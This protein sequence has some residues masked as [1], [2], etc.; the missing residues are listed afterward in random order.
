M[1]VCAITGRRLRHAPFH[2][3][4]PGSIFSCADLLVDAAVAEIVAEAAP[5]VAAAFAVASAAE[6]TVASAP[7][8]QTFRFQDLNDL[9]N[10]VRRNCGLAAP[11]PRDASQVVAPV[12]QA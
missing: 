6:D 1:I 4:L 12:S 10:F 7:A 8:G 3:P 2:V 5:V 9:V 11:F